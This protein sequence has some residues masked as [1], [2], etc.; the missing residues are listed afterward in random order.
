MAH[1][2]LLTIIR[3]E[4]QKAIAAAKKTKFGYVS[5]YN[6]KTHAVRVRL[7]PESSANEHAGLA[8]VE[9]NWIPL[10][11]MTTGSGWGVII[12]P[13]A[14][15][16]K[17]YGDQVLVVWADNGQGVAFQGFYNDVDQ[18]YPLSGDTPAGLAGTPAAGEY[19]LVHKSG[20]HLVIKNDGTISVRD[21]NGSLVTLNGDDS[22]SALAASGAKLELK[23]D[24]K[25]SM[26][27]SGGG[28]V[29]CD[30]TDVKIN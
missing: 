25:A 18:P 6:P 20:A 8:I 23:A 2:D 5:S 3:R 30:G 4:A 9:T 19:W 22:I 29:V 1:N 27:S 11:T 16:I 28:K 26:E 7:E 17:P 15:H 13:S 12:P 14:S 10:H 21:K 24:G